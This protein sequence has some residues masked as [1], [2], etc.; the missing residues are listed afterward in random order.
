M[1]KTAIRA[2]KGLV[3]FVVVVGL[4]FAALAGITFV[5][6]HWPA[7][8][9]A[10]DPD[11]RVK[12]YYLALG[13]SL[14]FGFQPN[15]NWDQG[16]PMIWWTELQRHG[17]TSFTDYA[18]NGQTTTGFI[19]GGCP[20]SWFRHNYYSKPQ[21]DAAIEFIHKHRGQVSPVS[22][23]I[24]A[25]DF[26]HDFD[27]AACR[28]DEKKMRRDLAMYDRQMT[29]IILPRLTKALDDEHGRRTGELVMMNYYDPWVNRCPKLHRYVALINRHIE[30]D[31]ARFDVPVVDVASAFEGKDICRYT[32]MCSGVHSVHPNTDGY[33][34]IAHA[35]ERTTGY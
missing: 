3:V 24:G 16:Y 25:D 1:R 12:P 31:A 30:R 20:Y 23:D 32:W 9:P 8:Y 7:T 10:T 34:L 21:L 17:S 35:F 13:D 15:F 2:L 33:G 27:A 26:V 14:A 28:A 22:L 11:P 6:T 4:M 5:P 19:H 18:C 29:R